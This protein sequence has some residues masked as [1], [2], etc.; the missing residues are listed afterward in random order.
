MTGNLAAYAGCMCIPG[1]VMHSRTSTTFPWGPPYREFPD[2]ISNATAPSAAAY[3]KVS[4]LVLLYVHGHV[5][6]ANYPRILS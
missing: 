3:K 6:H 5:L 2:S 4:T 1:K